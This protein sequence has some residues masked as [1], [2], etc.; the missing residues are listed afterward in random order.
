METLPIRVQLIQMRLGFGEGRFDKVHRGFTRGR[1]SMACK[2]LYFITPAGHGACGG[3][4]TGHLVCTK[5]S[6]L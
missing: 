4:V 1:A 5:E 3:D 6:D 2:S